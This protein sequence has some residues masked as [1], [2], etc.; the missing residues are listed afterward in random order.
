MRSWILLFALISALVFVDA[1]DEGEAKASIV[2]QNDSELNSEENT[3][4]EGEAKASIA[5]QNDSELNGEENVMEDIADEKD[6][7]DELSFDAKMEAPSGF[8]LTIPR[9]HI[10]AAK[11]LSVSI[12]LLLPGN[13][14][15]TLA[16]LSYCFHRLRYCK[17]VIFMLKFIEK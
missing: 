16:R 14:I 1:I 11:K 5:T 9:R 13:G 3:I 7:N 12:P 4:D 8:K 2:T 15:N 10:I 17:S 6:T